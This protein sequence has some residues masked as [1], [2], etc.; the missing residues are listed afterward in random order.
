M[1]A[2]SGTTARRAVV[3]GGAGFLG[4]HLCA[5]LL[6]Q[7]WHVTA[8]DNLVTGSLRN[9]APLLAR[10]HFRFLKHDVISPLALEADVIFN[11]A[12]C[13]SPRQMRNVA[14]A[15]TSSPR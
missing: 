10:E 14:V 6:Q 2:S 9:I 1:K 12:C 7:G 5:R 15:I 4:S 8:I 13:A 11:L 3:T